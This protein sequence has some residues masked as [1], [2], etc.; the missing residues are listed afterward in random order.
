MDSWFLRT[1][2]NHFTFHV[3]FSKFVLWLTVKPWCCGHSS[4][5]ERC[6]EAREWL[7][8]RWCRRHDYKNTDVA[9]Q[10]SLAST[11]TDLTFSASPSVP[12][13]IE[14]VAMN[15]HCQFWASKLEN[16]WC[17]AKTDSEIKFTSL[18]V[19][20]RTGGKLTVIFILLVTCIYIWFQVCNILSLLAVARMLDIHNNQGLIFLGNNQGLIQLMNLN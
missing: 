7:D 2:S 9:N 16:D 20:G 5:V 6:K 13:S 12:I 18:P 11:T 17:S 1:C 19:C 14:P 3:Q 15:L 8:G 10:V 4:G